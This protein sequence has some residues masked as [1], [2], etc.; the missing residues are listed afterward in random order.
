MGDDAAT[1]EQLR[2][3]LSEL[4]RF[5]DLYEAARTENARLHEQS[6]ALADILRLIVETPGDAQTILSRIAQH[7]TRIGRAVD[8]QVFRR[9][10]EWV[11][12]AA[13]DG[14]LP[15]ADAFGKPW[16]LGERRFVNEVIRQ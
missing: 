11:F 13:H 12:Y 9:D 5:R 15:S 7:A 8:T 14:P 2:A 4:C 10:G 16:P 3:E 6:L 1:V